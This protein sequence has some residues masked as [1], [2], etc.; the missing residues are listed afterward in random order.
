MARQSPEPTMW[1]L[2]VAGA[3]VPVVTL[4][5]GA[6]VVLLHGGGTSATEY[7]RLATRL[8]R[9]FTVHLYNRRGRPRAEPMH[10]SD[11]VGTDIEDL[12]AVLEATG[13]SRV[14][15]HSGGGFV[16]FQAARSL[17]I[18]HLATYDAAIA[19]EGTDIPKGYLGAFQD[20]LDGGDLVTAMSIVATAANP[21][22]TPRNMPPWLQRSLTAAFLKS[23]YGQRMKDLIHTFRPEIGRIL[24]NEE[25]ASF[26][27]TITAKVLLATG[28][29]SSAYF[30]QTCEALAEELPHGRRLV[31]PRARHNTA[32][33]APERLVQPLIDFFGDESGSTDAVRP[34]R[35]TGR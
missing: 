10:E 22:E 23:T 26:Y 27:S 14:F 11:T 4:G 9:R 32:N 28:S 29:H 18:S 13:S 15:A 24:D 35:E 16:A 17:P 21:D 12:A 5:A 7:M 8:S 3:Q 20:A 30:A 1:Q 25:P 31:V 6:G 33:S 19:I 34:A 2:I